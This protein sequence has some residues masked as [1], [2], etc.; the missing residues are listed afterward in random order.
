MLTLH[1]KRFNNV[2][3]TFRR[4]TNCIPISI[5]TPHSISNVA[6]TSELCSTANWSVTSDNK[7]NNDKSTNRYKYYD[8]SNCKYKTNTDQ[9]WGDGSVDDRIAVL[10]GMS[11]GVSIGR[12][13][14]RALRVRKDLRG[15]DCAA[16]DDV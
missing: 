8:V 5:S 4:S 11:V 6:G 12:A 14:L 13:L 16:G 3:Y 10:V 9:V 2:K 7:Y 1:S 15:A